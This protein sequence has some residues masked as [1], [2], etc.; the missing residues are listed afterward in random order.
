MGRPEFWN[1]LVSL[2][3][4]HGKWRYTV[5]NIT[6]DKGHHG[7]RT[8]TWEKAVDHLIWDDLLYSPD[9]P[10]LP[11]LQMNKLEGWITC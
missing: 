6:N 8:P 1:D 2:T 3:E 11:V 10:V 7:H 5:A 9:F 4:A